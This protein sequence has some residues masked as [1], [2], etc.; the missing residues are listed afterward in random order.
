[1][2]RD[3]PRRVARSRVALSAQRSNGFEI[4]HPA[5]MH[6]TR[7]VDGRAVVQ[8]RSNM[9]GVRRSRGS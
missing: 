2:G 9:G 5:W 3:E 1:M 7:E 4:H 8:K 6:G